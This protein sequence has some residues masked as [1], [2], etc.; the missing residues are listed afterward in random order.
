MQFL[1]QFRLFDYGADEILVIRSS[2]FE[3]EF[4]KGGVVV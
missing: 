1:F 3:F 2:R 4:E